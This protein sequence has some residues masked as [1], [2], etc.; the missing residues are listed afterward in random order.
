MRT[1]LATASLALLA[2]CGGAASN[3]IAGNIPAPTEATNEAAPAAPT[4]AANPQ[5][6]N[7]IQECVS[8]VA[9]ELPAG[10][11]VNAFCGCAVDKM[12]SGGLGER[13]AM[14]Q[15]AAQMGIQPRR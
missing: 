1:I 12:S 8:D 15:C 10:A 11:D 5:R 14:E 4:A 7:E 9:N 2:A 13:P 3:N 6:E